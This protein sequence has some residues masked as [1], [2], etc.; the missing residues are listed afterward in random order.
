MLRLLSLFLLLLAGTAA[1]VQAQAPRCD[2]SPLVVTNTNVWTRGTV[3]TNRDVVF[4]DGRV[5]AIVRAGRDTHA[6]LR[7]IDGTGHTLLPG[8]IDAHL[9]FTISGGLPAR[10]GPRPDLEAL[11]AQQVLRSGV[12]SGRLHLATIEEAARLKARSTDPCDAVPR[13]QVGGPGLSGALQKDS[14]NFQGVKS[15]EDAAAKIDRA[16]A[17]GID[18]VAVHNADRFAP[19]LLDAVAT[20]ARNAGV[21]VMAAGSTPEE[22]T[23]ALAIR[24]DTLDYFDQTTE[25]RYGAAML[26]RIKAQKNLVLVPTPGV[27]YRTIEYLRSPARL[28]HPANFDLLSAFDRAFVLANA[29]QALAGADGTRAQRIAPFLAEK[30]RQLRA[31]GL[32]MAVGSDAGSPVQF[33]ADA[34]WWELEAWRSTGASHREALLAATE[35]G[36]RVLDQGAR[37]A[38]EST[39]DARGPGKGRGEIGNLEVGSRA[40]FVLYRGNVEVGPFDGSRVLAVGKGGVLFLNAPRATSAAMLPDR[41]RTTGR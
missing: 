13:L 17:A 40:D 2:S 5:A 35:G 18:W 4:R 30:I 1:P 3:L 38:N 19:G 24:P 16:R 33:P 9:H 12:T 27:P 6:G 21:R 11:T 23:A 20:A 34:I 39:R 32:P 41:A 8:L 14:N 10:D 37:G 7:R 22:I 15:A 36:A 31:L 26:D 28:E 25:P 29:Q